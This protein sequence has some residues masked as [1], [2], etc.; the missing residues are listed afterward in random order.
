MKLAFYALSV[1]YVASSFY[2]NERLLGAQRQAEFWRE[3][4]RQ[5]SAES[6]LT[7]CVDLDRNYVVCQKARHGE[8]R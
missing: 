7:D 4:Y 1:L 5:A 6:K 2:W 8:K 3:M